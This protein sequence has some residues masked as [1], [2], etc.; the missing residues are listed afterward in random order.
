MPEEKRGE[1]VREKKV[2]GNA[3]NRGREKL[4]RL[5]IGK[6]DGLRKDK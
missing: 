3:R 4:G 2:T 5:G 6:G 1:E